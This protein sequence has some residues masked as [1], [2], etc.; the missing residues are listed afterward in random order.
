RGTGPGEPARP[1]RVGAGTGFGLGAEQGDLPGLDALDDEVGEYRLPLLVE[2]REGRFEIVVEQSGR[3][4][5]DP[6]LPA[7][8]R[9]GRHIPADHLAQ[10]LP[11]RTRAGGEFS[12]V[13]EV[14]AA[15]MIEGGGHERLL[16][17]D[18]VDDEPRAQAQ[19]IGDVGHPQGPQTCGFDLLDRGRQYLL[20]ANLSA[21][22]RHVS[23]VVAVRP[24]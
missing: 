5:V 21:L 14:A 24:V 23:P 6:D 9:T 22:P 17:R 3:P 10:P 4:A 12:G 16:R 1:L 20:A 18:V 15:G 11:G 2:S 7:A 19:T 8:C 13:F